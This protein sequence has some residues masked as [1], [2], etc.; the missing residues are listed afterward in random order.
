MEKVYKPK[1]LFLVEA[2]ALKFSLEHMNIHSVPF[3]QNIYIS[4]MEGNESVS[5]YK[6]ATGKDRGIRIALKAK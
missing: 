5:L 1:K 6:K 4:S 2:C 3:I